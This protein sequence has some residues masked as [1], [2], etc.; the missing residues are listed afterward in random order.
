MGARKT[1]E[2]VDV[3]SVAEKSKYLLKY[4]LLSVC[5]LFRAHVTDLTI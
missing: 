5:V 1:N 3:G 2:A 4:Q